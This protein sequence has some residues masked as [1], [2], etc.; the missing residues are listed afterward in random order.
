MRLQ[1]RDDADGE[2]PLASQRANG[3]R[4]GAGG[5]A[6]DL[7]EQAPPVQTVRTQ[8][9]GDGEH[10]L[11]VRHRREERGVEPLRP[12]RQPF[13]VAVRAEVATR[14]GER[15]QI[16]VGTGVAADAG[17]DAWGRRGL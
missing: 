15:D 2:F 5:D 4:D 6:G 17:G 8:P 1:A 3:G 14:A 11:P 10:H 9:L 16:L 13:G 7:A 12:D